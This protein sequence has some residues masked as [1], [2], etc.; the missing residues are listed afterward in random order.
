MDLGAV[1]EIRGF[2]YLARQDGGWNGA[3]GKTEFY[4]GNSSDTFTKLAVKATFKKVRRP[5]AVDCEKP[6]RGRYVRVRI[7][8]EVANNPSASASAL[9][10]G[11]VGGLESPAHD[12]V[13]G[14][15]CHPEREEEMPRSFGRL[16]QAFI[17]RAEMAADRHAARA[18]G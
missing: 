13:I 12:W 7:L 17:E 4:V 11:L 9:G 14:V 5:Q 8:S 16:F 1:Y 2:R 15:Q 10:D 3:F 18:F 6:I